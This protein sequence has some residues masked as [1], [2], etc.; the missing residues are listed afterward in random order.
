MW[1]PT[2]VQ[3]LGFYQRWLIISYISLL[4]F[5]SSEP[6]GWRLRVKMGQTTLSSPLASARRS[7]RRRWLRRSRTPWSGWSSVNCMTIW[8]SNFIVKEWAQKI[9]GS[10]GSRARA[11]QRKL[12][13]PSS[14]ETSS[15]LMS[16]WAG[17]RCRSATSTITTNPSPGM[18]MMYVS[19]GSL[20]TS[21]MSPGGIHCSAN[22]AR[23]R[24]TIEE[25]LRS[26]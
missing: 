9:N 2:H 5:Q 11:T 14:T 3:V 24:Q 15:V 25:S 8:H 12:S 4:N 17:C 6:R 22:L 20:F 16:S 23:A 19:E 13:S 18:S 10:E 7:S 1:S 26:G 21:S